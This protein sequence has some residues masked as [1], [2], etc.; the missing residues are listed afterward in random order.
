[1]KEIAESLAES[2]IAL[3]NT[4]DE[5]ARRRIA[6]GIF[7]EDAIMTYPTLQAEGIDGI[8]ATIGRFQEQFPGARFEAVS[9][10]EYHHGWM[11]DSWRM[12]TAEGAIALEGEDVCELAE[13]G[14][15]R[16]AIGFRN[17][18]PSVSSS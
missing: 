17:P 14:R 13:E 8:V 3:W 15:L 2:V 12:V 10:V 4:T 16:R 5:E 9:G 11:R 18:L 7:T 6:D 1:M